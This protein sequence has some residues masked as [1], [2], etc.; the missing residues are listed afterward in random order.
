MR[1]EGTVGSS[2]NS[3]PLTKTRELR[4]FTWP[5]QDVRSRWATWAARRSVLHRNQRRSSVRPTVW[6]AQS[7]CHWGLLPNQRPFRSD[8]QC[9]TSTG[10]ESG[11][12]RMD[13]VL[14]EFVSESWGEPRT[15]GRNEIV[16][17]SRPAAGTASE[18]LPPRSQPR[19]CGAV[20][21]DRLG[22][23]HSAE[24]VLGQDARQQTGVSESAISITLKAIDRIR[25][26]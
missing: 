6:I 20:G 9:G 15:A 8:G 26:C 7:T 5:N 16:E 10:F 19:T 21:L 2:R 14:Q 11:C 12:S 24:N 23:A 4:K 22:I 1:G 13:D 17:A 18:T 3:K 25:T